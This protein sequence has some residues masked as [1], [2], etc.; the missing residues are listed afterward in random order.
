[1]IRVFR[2]Y[3]QLPLLVLGVIEFVALLAAATL[4]WQGRLWQANLPF[5]SVLSFLP[6]VLTYAVTT[7]LV[8]LAVGLYQSQ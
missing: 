3:V 5:G 1:M 6:E 4:A 2:H 8:M 7:Y